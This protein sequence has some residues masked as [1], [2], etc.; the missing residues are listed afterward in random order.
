MVSRYQTA[1]SYTA[2]SYPIPIRFLYGSAAEIDFWDVVCCHAY[3]AGGAFDT[4]TPELMAETG[5]S[6]PMLGQL[7]CRAIAQGDLYQDSSLVSGRRFILQV[8]GYAQMIYQLDIAQNLALPRGFIWKP[9]NYVRQGWHH[10]IMPAIPKRV[11]NLYL[12]QPRQRVYTLTPQYI[13]K[14]CK[15]TLIYETYG[16]STP[17]NLADVGKALRLLVRLGLFLPVNVPSG[18]N[19]LPGE[20]FRINWEVFNQPAPVDAPAF[21]EDDPREHPAFQTLVQIDPQ[22]A[23]L[24]LELLDTGNYGIAHLAEIFRDLAYISE[25]DYALLKA[26]VYRRRNRPPGMQRWR[27]TWRAFQKAVQQRITHTRGMKK[28]LWLEQV[29]TGKLSLA[30]DESPSHLLAVW[31]V[32]RVEWPWHL[33]IPTITVQFTLWAGERKLHQWTAHPGDM[34]TRCPLHPE[35]WTALATQIYLTVHCEQQV[36]GMHV[37]AWLEARVQKQL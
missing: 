11:L 25:T 1:I 28:T 23:G 36:P 19:T 4:S 12:Q 30:L 20:G 31:L 6:R 17:L 32:S 27:D 8:P 7:R 34:E 24:A 26:K 35:A 2:G 10:V 21:A 22:R 9:L 15:R 14:K 3:Q 16:P 5:L 37:E 33:E 18:D 29:T 13:A